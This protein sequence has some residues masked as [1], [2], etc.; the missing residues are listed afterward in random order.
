M[1][2]AEKD[3][4]IYDIARATVVMEEQ[5]QNTLREAQLLQ[6]LINIGNQTRVEVAQLELD[7]AMARLE[8]LKTM[9]VMESS[10]LHSIIPENTYQP[11]QTPATEI[12]TTAEEV[13]D[14]NTTNAPT[15]EAVEAPAEHNSQP[16]AGGS[17]QNQGK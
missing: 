6:I 17:S 7:T 8:I 14:Q 13:P 3:N 9:Q 15:S 5:K 4:N 1:Q 11:N 16:T 12:K 2:N 10:Q